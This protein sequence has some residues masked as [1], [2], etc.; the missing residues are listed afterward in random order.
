[1]IAWDTETDTFREG[2]WL[3]GRVYERR[4]DLSPNGELL[5][6]FAAKYKRHLRNLDK[7][8]ATFPTWT[9][10]SRPPYFSALSLW[11]HA[12]AWNGGGLF[13]SDRRLL[14]NHGSRVPKPAPGLGPPDK[15]I[16]EV[17]PFGGPRGEDDT[18]QHPRLLRDGWRLQRPGNAIHRPNGDPRFVYDP[19]CEYRRSQPADPPAQ[20]V[21]AVHGLG[22]ANGPWY[23]ETFHVRAPARQIDFA[24]EGAQWADWDR[25]GDLLFARNG[26]LFRLPAD[27][28]R[29]ATAGAR[30]LADFGPRHPGPVPP[31]PAARSW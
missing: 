28:L 23:V 25:T 29:E 26:A 18:I 3:G 6:Y 5:V 14:L 15:S 21:R 22:K 31:P 2:Q 20:L 17:V 16:L 7:D 12:S 30:L 19:P 27:K 4:C 10:V 11:P 13:E 24:V 9:A 1:M 8:T